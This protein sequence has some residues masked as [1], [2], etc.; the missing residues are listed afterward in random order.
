MQKAHLG[1]LILQF[2]EKR[3]G[4]SEQVNKTSVIAENALINL[5]LNRPNRQWNVSERSMCATISLTQLYKSGLNSGNR[6]FSL[7]PLRSK[8]IEDHMIWIIQVSEKGNWPYAVISTRAAGPRSLLILLPPFPVYSPHPQTSNYIMILF[9]CSCNLFGLSHTLSEPPLSK[10]THTDF[11]MLLGIWL[12]DGGGFYSWTVLI[13]SD[14][15]LDPHAY[16]TR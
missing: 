7:L 9:F 12:S 2:A 13:M 16:T 5:Y 1:L 15:L 6:D 10:H 14:R 4:C 8:T 11:Q 3:E